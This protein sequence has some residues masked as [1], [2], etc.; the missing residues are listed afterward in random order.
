VGSRPISVL[1]QNCAAVEMLLQ[2][3]LLFCTETAQ[4]ACVGWL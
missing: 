4:C 2:L 1:Q 3:L